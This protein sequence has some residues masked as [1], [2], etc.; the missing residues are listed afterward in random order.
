[1]ADDTPN[2]WVAFSR[3]HDQPDSAALPAAKADL[4]EQR[5][6][7]IGDDDPE[8]ALS[9]T[10]DLENGRLIVDIA[11]HNGPGL[12]IRLPRKAIDR[13]ARANTDPLTLVA[14]AM[15]ARTELDETR[16][17]KPVGG[18]T[19]PIGP[20]LDKLLS[21]HRLTD[22]DHE[23][24]LAL[25]EGRDVV[26]IGN[27]GAGKTA[28]ATVH[29]RRCIA[30][31]GY[32]GVWLDL[33]DPADGPES[34][35]VRL[36]VS[37]RH[38]QYLIFVDSVQANP[39]GFESVLECVQ[40]LRTEFGLTVQILATAWPKLVQ[41]WREPFKEF[42][43]VTAQTDEIIRSLIAD[44]DVPAHERHKILKL[45]RDDVH[46]AVDAVAFWTRHGRAPTVSDLQSAFTEGVDDDAHRETLYWFASLGFFGLDSSADAAGARL[47]HIAIEWLVERGLIAHSDGRYSI[48]SHARA[49]L[50]LRQALTKWDAAKRWGAPEQL[51]REHIKRGGERVIR[52]TLGRLDLIGVSG[53]VSAPFNATPRYLARAWDLFTQL[54]RAL[55]RWCVNEAWNDN[56][57]AAIFAA[58]ALVVMD[59]VKAWEKIGGYVRSR[60][61]Y[62]VPGALPVPVGD[63]S[64]ESH[65]FEQK[66]GR[67]HV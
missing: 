12:K 13:A 2:S 56:V 59:D 34:I 8:L 42:R 65:D 53:D 27:Y 44:A 49:R 10:V 51:A 7:A 17:W 48:P 33:T 4:D 41:T 37:R 15:T 64:R 52:A 6:Q 18:T 39:A 57:P 19:P 16:R 29:T 62:D 46:L 38:A 1:M 14:C 23:I 9:C 5:R 50:A 24:Q 25:E 58:R 61:I 32:G 31:S 20:A 55:A 35:W 11:P 63:P 28:T 45:V 26:L 67:A 40:S 21:A 66:I 54:S 30:D 36:L 47:P 22:A 3:I 60:W 43:K